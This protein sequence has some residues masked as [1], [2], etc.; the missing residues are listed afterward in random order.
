MKTLLILICLTIGIL[1]VYCAS[2]INKPTKL[3]TTKQIADDTTTTTNTAAATA[4]ASAPVAAIALTNDATK[5]KRETKDTKDASTVYA[6]HRS[7]TATAIVHRNTNANDDD[8]ESPQ[9]T[10]YGTNARQFLIRPQ[11]QHLQQQQQQN[12]EEQLPPQLR[13]YPATIRPHNTQLLEQSQE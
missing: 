3:T 9:E 12:E 13:N 2:E 4:A 10:V 11:Q 1:N 6:N 8:P 7:D 5:D